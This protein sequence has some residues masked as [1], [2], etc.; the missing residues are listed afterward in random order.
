MLSK[1]YKFLPV[2][3]SIISILMIMGIFDTFARFH[4]VSI[5]DITSS[6]TF[7]SLESE[8]FDHSIYV[9][10]GIL[11][12]L[13]VDHFLT[14]STL[15]SP[16][17][18]THVESYVLPLLIVIFQTFYIYF[19]AAVPG[20]TYFWIYHGTLY[21]NICVL[22]N[23]IFVIQ[24]HAIQN[25]ATPKMLRYIL[26]TM[27]LFNASLIVKLLVTLYNIQPLF[28]IWI[29]ILLA[30]FIGSC[31]ILYE[32]F[33]RYQTAVRTGMKNHCFAFSFWE[34]FLITSFVLVIE[35]FDMITAENRIFDSSATRCVFYN[36][37]IICCFFLLSELYILKNKHIA[38]QSLVSTL[39]AL[40]CLFCR[41]MNHFYN[42]SNL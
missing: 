40:S 2:G 30:E 34:M 7:S 9:S 35:I 25:D 3:I 37:I 16:E 4:E 23:A 29:I 10:M 28:Y 27:T 5:E 42:Y 12:P 41:L 1:Y 39:S 15:W 33:S 31:M 21:Y 14:F 32:W 22:C 13:T 18:F 38:Q 17:V 24:I 11:I 20:K 36:M 26:T 6:K 19:A 8:A